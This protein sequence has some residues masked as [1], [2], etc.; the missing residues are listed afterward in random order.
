MHRI[1]SSKSETN[2]DGTVTVT[3]FE[4]GQ[5]VPADTV[6]YPD[7]RTASIESM[8]VHFPNTDREFLV[9]A[10]DHNARTQARIAKQRSS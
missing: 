4:E 7:S 10:H 2:A 3:Y 6:T 5:T 8:M 9:R 1:T